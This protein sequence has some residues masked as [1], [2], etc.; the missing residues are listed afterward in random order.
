MVALEDGFEGWEPFALKIVHRMARKRG[1]C[2]VA[3]LIF[4]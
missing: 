4:I 1:K 3:V 2:E